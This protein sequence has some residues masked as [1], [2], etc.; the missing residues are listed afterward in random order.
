MVNRRGLTG[1][2]SLPASKTELSKMKAELE[3]FRDQIQYKRSDLPELYSKIGAYKDSVRAMQKT[4]ELSANRARYLELSAAKFFIPAAKLMQASLEIVETIK[5]ESSDMYKAMLFEDKKRL[6]EQIFEE[7]VAHV[8]LKKPQ[9]ASQWQLKALQDSPKLAELSQ[10]YQF[11]TGAMSLNAPS[12][13]SE[14]DLIMAPADFDFKPDAN[15]IVY[16]TSLLKAL[17]TLNSLDGSLIVLVQRI[18]SELFD[19]VEHEIKTVKE[20]LR[21]HPDASTAGSDKYVLVGVHSNLSRNEFFAICPVIRELTSAVILKLTAV[22]NVFKFITTTVN[23]LYD[24]A[25]PFGHGQ[26][27]LQRAIHAAHREIR[28]FIVAFIYGSQAPSNAFCNPVADIADILRNSKTKSTASKA[29]LFEFVP[30]ADAA[31]AAEIKTMSIQPS[32]R[33]KAFSRKLAATMNIDPYSSLRRDTG[34]QLIARPSMQFAGL[35]YSQIKLFSAILQELEG[36]DAFDSGEQALGVALLEGILD[37]EYIPLVESYALQE[38]SASFKGID[39]N[40]WTNLSTDVIKQEYITGRSS[41]SVLNCYLTFV[42]LCS[43]ICRLIYFIPEYQCDFERITE[44]LMDQVLDKS[45]IKLRDL[46]V[47]KSTA[48]DEEVAT[49][50]CLSVQFAKNQEV[51]DILAQNSLL[52]HSADAHLNELLAEKETVLMERLKSDRS[53]NKSELISDPKTIRNLALL[54]RSFEQLGAL[55]MSGAYLPAH[56]AQGRGMTKLA[57][58]GRRELHLHVYDEGQKRVFKLGTSLEAKLIVFAELLEKLAQT[59]LY[60]LHSEVRTH[61]FFYLD[62][63]AREGTYR[64]DVAT[65]E[66]DPYVLSLNADLLG[67]SSSVAEWFPQSKYLFLFDCLHVFMDAV[68]VNN[69]RYIKELNA[70]GAQKLRT[71]VAAL[72]QVLTQLLPPSQAVLPR[73]SEYFRLAQLGAP[74]LMGALGSAARRFTHLQCRALFDAAY[75]EALQRDT[76]D[77]TRQ[78]YLNQLTALKYHFEGA[79]HG[80]V[81]EEDA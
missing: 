20:R 39:S 16:V 68:L 56:V 55:L 45:E 58:D 52:Q 46:I 81:H 69:F 61:C 57:F 4:I 70:H 35:L 75:G 72:V 43:E 24:G 10:S 15:S 50:L 2:N 23:H 18:S 11:F 42:R 66:P 3:A 9:A 1:T 29:S 74:A 33:E 5:I 80:A 38:L 30:F 34:H 67:L 32:E 59:C 19:A 26:T 48:G 41:N 71:N 63:A 77:A 21:A 51:R 37:K 62:L 7:L 76:T 64:L 6:S 78:A 12:A 25:D 28:N 22:A 79:G 53:I 40:A 36:E 27:P 49:T 47:A 14:T 60:T 13:S 73:A 31:A 54:Q 8:F 17:H 44:A 65:D